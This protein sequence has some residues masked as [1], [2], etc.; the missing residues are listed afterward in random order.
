MNKNGIPG[1]NLKYQHCLAFQTYLKDR[2]L[3]IVLKNIDK[4]FKLGL[5][6]S[7]RDLTLEQIPAMRIYFLAFDCLSSHI[8]RTF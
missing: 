8:R 4:S 1:G 6:Q 5:T 2:N 3:S 7:S